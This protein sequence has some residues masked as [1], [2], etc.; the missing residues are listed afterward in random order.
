[1]NRDPEGQPCITSPDPFTAKVSE[2]FKAV[3][4]KIHLCGYI[5]EAH[6]YIKKAKAK[7]VFVN[8]ANLSFDYFC[9]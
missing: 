2:N 9:L 8:D 5:L 3:Y 7:V 6:F 4:K 1:M